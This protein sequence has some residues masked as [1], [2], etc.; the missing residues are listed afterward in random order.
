[1]WAHYADN[2]CGSCMEYDLHSLP[3]EINANI[4]PIF[5]TGQ[6]PEYTRLIMDILTASENKNIDCVLTATFI[7]STD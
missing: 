2:H 4:Y 6:R 3:D 7:K 5:Y 1:M